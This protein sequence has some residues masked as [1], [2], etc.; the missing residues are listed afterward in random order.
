MW[1]LNLI[2]AHLSLAWHA[3]LGLQEEMK[4]FPP[5]GGASN[6]TESVLRV[7][8]RSYS[9]QIFVWLIEF[10]RGSE[11]GRLSTDPQDVSFQRRFFKVYV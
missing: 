3:V 10:H 5:R 2:F 7:Y 6:S 9:I 8:N 4:L 11:H 1:F